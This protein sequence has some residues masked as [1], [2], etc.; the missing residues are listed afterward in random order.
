MF[1]SST[2]WR[3]S[4]RS[5]SGSGNCVEVRIVTNATSA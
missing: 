1:Q 3:K 2:D 5:G 4:S